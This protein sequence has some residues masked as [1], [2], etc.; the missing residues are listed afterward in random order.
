M[1]AFI[2]VIIICGLAISGYIVALLIKI[3]K[4]K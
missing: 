4:S 2:I 3:L 1:T